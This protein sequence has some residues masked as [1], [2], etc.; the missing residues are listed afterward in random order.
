MEA[1]T[2]RRGYILLETVVATGLLIVGLAVI[3][4]QIQ[5]AGS[6]IQKMERQTRAMLLAERYFA[7]MDLGLV[8]LDSVDEIQEGDFGPREPDWGWRLITELTAVDGM[9]RL[10]LE[11]LHY[12]RKDDYREDD[13]PYDDAEK[14]FVTYA[15]RAGAQALDLGTD[16]GLTENELLEVAK[17]AAECGL[18]GFDP[19]TFDPAMMAKLET[20]ELI[21]CLPVV[22]DFLGQDVGAL[23]A[24]LP[25]AAVEELKSAGVFGDEGDTNDPGGGEGGG[26]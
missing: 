10:T 5:D 6:S 25:A 14:V 7:Y 22:L 18:Q 23:E 16:F 19:L 24:L 13:F 8:E 17:K 1:A 15:F 4:V 11:I 12:I 26:P 21:K 3:G 9:Y 2:V 20:E